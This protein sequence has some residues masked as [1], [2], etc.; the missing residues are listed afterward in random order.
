MDSTSVGR[1]VA[2]SRSGRPVVTGHLKRMAV[3]RWCEMVEV[4]SKR[5]AVMARVVTY[6]M[7]RGAAA[8]A[9]ALLGLAEPLAGLP[10]ADLTGGAPLAVLEAAAG[11]PAVAGLPAAPLTGLPVASLTD[12]PAAGLATSLAGTVPCMILSISSN[13]SSRPALPVASS[14]SDTAMHGR[15]STTASAGFTPRRARA[16][17][18]WLTALASR[19]PALDRSWSK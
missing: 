10:L 6:D 13:T 7:G 17:C 18:A 5:S 3:L 12:L 1:P 4:Q 8:G 16:S 11:F 2:S 15:S 9:A 14:S 19:N